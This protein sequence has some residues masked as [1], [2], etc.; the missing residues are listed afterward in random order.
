MFPAG[1]VRHFTT[2]DDKNMALSMWALCPCATTADGEKQYTAI[3]QA[4]GYGGLWHFPS[5]MTLVVRFEPAPGDTAVVNLG[6]ELERALRASAS[7]GRP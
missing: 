6:Q 2:L 1:D 4:V 3:G 5:G 7:A